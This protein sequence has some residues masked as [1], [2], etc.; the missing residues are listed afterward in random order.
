MTARAAELSSHNYNY[1]LMKLKFLR[2]VYQPK[3][4][5]FPGKE[6]IINLME[7]AWQGDGEGG[8]GGGGGRKTMKN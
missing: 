2:F 8:V 7:L 6:I 4:I 5:S 1:N 3:Q